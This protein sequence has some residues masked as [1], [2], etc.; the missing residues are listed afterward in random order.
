MIARTVRL[1]PRYLD[2]Y[3]DSPSPISHPVERI[4]IAG[5][6]RVR[7]FDRRDM[8]EE[9][10]LLEAISLLTEEEGIVIVGYNSLMFDLPFMSMRAVALGLPSSLIGRLRQT[11]HVDLA[12]LVHRYL[13]P[14]NRHTNWR[15]ISPILDLP[16]DASK[17]DVTR[18][19]YE[20]IN[21]LAVQNIQSRYS[22]L[23][24][25]AIVFDDAR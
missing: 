23:R 21:A 5:Q 18:E 3:T 16:A 1:S 9:D 22:P 2:V 15:E 10:I 20:R 11:Y 8:D 19:L 13:Q 25:C 17:I 6:T 4:T 24:N 12:H 7:R 14:F